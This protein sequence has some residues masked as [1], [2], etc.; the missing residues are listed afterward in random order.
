MVTKTELHQARKNLLDAGA[1]LVFQGEGVLHVDYLGS[2][3]PYDNTDTELAL[4]K[5]ILSIWKNNT[6]NVDNI[7]K[8]KIRNYDN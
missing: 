4:L 5:K 1:S 6:Y 2:K 8:V 3:S 7:K